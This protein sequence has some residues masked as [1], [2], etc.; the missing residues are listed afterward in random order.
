M[1]ILIKSMWEMI[2]MEIRNATISFSINKKKKDSQ[3]E[4]GLWLKLKQLHE[5]IEK[6][7]NDKAI[8]E[9]ISQTENELA[10]I[11]NE[12]NQW[13]NNKIKNQMD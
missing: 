13:F 3:Y 5:C 9:E 8:I 12:K 11:E 10:S 6:K 4:K 2:K 7:Y 1:K